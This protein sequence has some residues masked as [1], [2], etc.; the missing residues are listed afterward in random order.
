MYIEKRRR[1]RGATDGYYT[2]HFEPLKV[3][4]G[5]AN[6]HGLVVEAVLKH[7]ERVRCLRG[8]QWAQPHNIFNSHHHRSPPRS[9][10]DRRLLATQGAVKE[11][12][13]LFSHP[14]SHFRPFSS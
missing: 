2:P 11:N 10:A 5:V 14:P 8:S 12:L 9:V 6:E 4:S 1:A 3:V 13:F 7:P